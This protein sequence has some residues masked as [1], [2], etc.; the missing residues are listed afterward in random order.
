MSYRKRAKVNGLK[1]ETKAAE[2]LSSFFN[3]TNVEFINDIADFYVGG[4]YIEVKSCQA[5]QKDTSHSK[6]RRRGRFVL[7]K[8]QHEFLLKNDGYYLFLVKTSK[9]IFLRLMKAKDVPAVFD[10]N[11]R[12]L[13]AWTK[14]IEEV[15]T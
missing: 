2:Y 6:N 3:P 7:Y 13:L 9:G 14:V 12:C 11:D 8:N 5:W 4:K 10:R 15:I 1:A